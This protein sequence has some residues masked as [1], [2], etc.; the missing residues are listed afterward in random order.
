MAV[1]NFAYTGEIIINAENVLEIYLM[2]YNLG[3]NK[4]INW[5]TDFMKARWRKLLQ[6]TTS[7]CA[8]GAAHIPGVGE[9][10]VGGSKKTEDGKWVDVDNAEIF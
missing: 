1:V 8:T 7:R 3:C 5:T 6:M 4:L 9:I 10:V 2:A